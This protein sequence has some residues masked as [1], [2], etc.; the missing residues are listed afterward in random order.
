MTSHHRLAVRPA[1]ISDLPEVIRLMALMHEDEPAPLT[2]VNADLT[3]IFVDI[4]SDTRRRLI[5]GLVDETV[6]GTAD[7][8]MV[9]N[10]SRGGRPWATVE[11]VVVDPAYR[12]RGLARKMMLHLMNEATNAGCY[13]V[14]LISHSRR[15]EAHRLYETL[16]FDAPVRGFRKYIS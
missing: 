2:H 8:I 10:L 6:A 13:K 5:V 9:N 15:I 1:L 11:N 4:S 3:A 7:M 12:R 14:Q 16:R